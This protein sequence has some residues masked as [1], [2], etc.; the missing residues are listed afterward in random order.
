MAGFL[1]ALG[2]DG[3]ALPDDPAQH[4]A[5]FRTVLARRRMLVVLDNAAT[6]EQVRP[7]L[8]GT[9]SGLVLVTSRDSLAGLVAGNGAH[10]IHVDRMRADEAERLLAK[11]LGRRIAEDAGAASLIERCARLPLALCIAAERI[12]ERGGE[13]TVDLDTELADERHRLDLLDTGDPHASVRAVLSWSYRHLPPA[14]ARLFRICGLRPGQDIDLHAL[15]ALAGADTGTTRRRL[16]VL[17]RAHLVER[18]ERHRYRQHDLLW[19][20]AAGLAH[21]TDPEPEREAARSRLLDHYL[22]MLAVSRRAGCRLG[23]LKASAGLG[24]SDMWSGRYAEG[25]DHYRR[26]LDIV[27]E[28]GFRASG[29]TAILGL[30][31]V[32]IL[33]GRYRQAAEHNRQGLRLAREIGHR[34]GELAAPA[35]LGELDERTG[36]HDAAAERYEQAL[37]LARAIGTH[38]NEVHLLVRLGH[39]HGEAGRRPTAAEHFRLAHTSAQDSD[40]HIGVVLALDGLGRTSC[41]TGDLPAAL[42][43]HRDGLARAEKLEL[44]RERAA[45]HDG[46]AH[47]HLTIGERERARHHGERALDIG[48]ALGLPEARDV[49]DRLAE[50]TPGSALWSRP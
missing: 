39:I 19:A 29:L 13:S 18:T 14:S 2:S 25:E 3:A 49:R 47:V 35:A 32:H 9:S 40:H 34:L 33:T 41:T 1:R 26:S 17:V 6:V 38:S 11:R 37:A 22:R 10:R 46:I 43:H 36:H 28:T 30:A 23:V 8:P 15:S 12:S 42:A 4:A 24:H 48:H 5:R 50:M 31:H 27:R 44:P 20:Y 21:A 16:D 7:L 45:A